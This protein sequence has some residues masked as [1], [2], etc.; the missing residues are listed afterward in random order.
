MRI[1]GGG[2]GGSLRQ[3]LEATSQGHIN[4]NVK[5]DAFPGQIRPSS[6]SRCIAIYEVAGC[7]HDEDMATAFNKEA[8]RSHTDRVFSM[9]FA[10]DDS[11]IFS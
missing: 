2:K 3:V 4:T 5:Q 9:C 8:C 1:S 10:N 7:K 11:P 6:V